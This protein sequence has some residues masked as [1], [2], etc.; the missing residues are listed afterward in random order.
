MEYSLRAIPLGGYVGFPDDDPQ[1]GF[2]ENDP[3]LLKNRGL[4]DRA[5][6]I[7]AGVAANFVFAFLILLTQVLPP[8]LPAAAA[9]PACVPPFASGPAVLP[10]RGLPLDSTPF[11]RAT[12]SW[13]CESEFRSHVCSTASTQVTWVVERGASLRHLRELLGAVC[14]LSRSPAASR[15]VL[16]GSRG[17]A[18]CHTCGFG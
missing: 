4:R 9:A 18:A 11:L 17:S 2:P 12:S 14:V 10:R 15:C 13:V 1:N 7:S 3:D 16:P 5:L 6:V 8:C